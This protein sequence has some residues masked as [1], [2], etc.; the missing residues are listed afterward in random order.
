MAKIRVPAQY[1]QAGDVVGSGEVIV[2]VQVGIRTPRG[3][4]EVVLIR[5]GVARLA[6]WKKATFINATRPEKETV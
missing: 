3:Q 5:G 6:F 1:L 4:V 2:S